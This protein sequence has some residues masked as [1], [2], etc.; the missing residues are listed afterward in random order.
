MDANASLM[1]AVSK[2]RQIVLGSIMHSAGCLSLETLL[3]NL[4]DGL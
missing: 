1:G 2:F 4:D 3:A